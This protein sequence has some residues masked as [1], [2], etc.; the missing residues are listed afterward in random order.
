MQANVAFFLAP[1]QPTTMG[2]PGS[3]Q[4]DITAVYPKVVLCHELAQ[5]CNRAHT[6]RWNKQG[7]GDKS[8]CFLLIAVGTGKCVHSWQIKS[9]IAKTKLKYRLGAQAKQNYQ[10]EQQPRSWK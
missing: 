6:Q 5:S 3:C 4:R 8:A 2:R 7:L 9:S 10:Y 1:F